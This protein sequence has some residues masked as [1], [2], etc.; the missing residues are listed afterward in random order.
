MK[1]ITK[2]AASILLTAFLVVAHIE[3][4]AQEQPSF[5]GQSIKIIVGFTSG[6]FL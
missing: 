5:Q 6:G 3:S 4:N 1:S 2:L